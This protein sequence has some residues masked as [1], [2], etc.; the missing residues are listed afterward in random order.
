MNQRETEPLSPL[1]ERARAQVRHWAPP[2]ADPDFR[3]RLKQ[4]FVAG[5]I[6]A[7]APA[8]PATVHPLPAP[9]FR[10]RPVHWAVAFAAAAAVAVV[11]GVANRGADWRVLGVTGEGLA[12]IDG[13]PVP[14]NHADQ[15]AAM[16]RPGARVRLPDGATL[17]LASAG[18]VAVEMT[19]GADVVVPAVPGRWF[20]RTVHS[21]VQG[22]ELRITTG[23]RFHGAHLVLSTPSATVEVTGTTLA[24]I[25]EAE[26]TC[27]CVLE[28]RV[29][30][31][32]RAGDM[33]A[34]EHLHRRFV[35]NDDRAP[36]YDDIRPG[37]I[38]TLSEF[39]EAR[40]QIMLS[41]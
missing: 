35:Y 3:A 30:V 6:E 37:E 13:R 11:I 17:E 29:M 25:C 39:R 22:G 27:V 14:L 28:G 36:V 8:R 1:Q 15:I 5:E 32:P 41:R 20:G 2:P 24:V 31:G 40:R 10:L 7:L 12:V 18:Q 16:T 38:G 21:E 34:V 19:S 9:R 33:L 23:P 4:A 26:G